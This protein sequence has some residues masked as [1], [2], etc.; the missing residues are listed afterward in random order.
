MIDDNTCVYSYL[1]WSSLWV[2]AL[3]NYSFTSPRRRMLCS[4]EDCHYIL[5]WFPPRV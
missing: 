3:G 4:T 5:P 1:I 2:S